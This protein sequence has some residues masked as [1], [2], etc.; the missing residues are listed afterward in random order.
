[1]SNIANDLKTVDNKLTRTGLVAPGE[2]APDFTLPDQ[3]GHPIS[4]TDFAGKSNVVVFFYPK[5]MSPGCTAEACAFR[6]GYEAFHEAGAE[7]IG[8][9]MD[10]VEA[11]NKFAA[12]NHFQFKLLSD[13]GGNVWNAYGIQNTFGIIRGRVTFVIDKAGVVRNVFSSQLQMDKH[14]TEALNILKGL[15]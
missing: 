6:D 1:L 9:S 4:L 11:Q 3:D 7:V 5:A 8:I 14:V 10:S 12:R 13:K 2:R 15:K